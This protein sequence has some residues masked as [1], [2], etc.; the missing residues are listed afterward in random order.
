MT[1]SEKDS[2]YLWHP[3]TQ[4]KTAAVPIAISRGEGV[5]L[6]DENNKEYI[7]AIASWWVNPFGHSNRFIADAIYKQLTTLEH[8]LF[9]GFTHEPAI[10]LAERLIEILP[11]N[12]QKIFFSDN[13]STAVEVAIKVALQYF[14]NKGEKRTTIIA[15]ENAFHGDTFAAMAASG[16]SFYT[17]A[18]QGMFI[19]V[20]R[21]PVPVKG[22]EQVSFDVLKEVIRDKK[23]AGF[24]FEPLV[25]GAAGMVMY[26]P[27]ALATLIEI[28]K[29]NNVLTI[30]DEVMT[31]F[32]KT[33]KTFA[34][35]YLDENPDMMC[36]SKALTGGTIPMAITTFTQEV[37]EAFYD[38]DINKA[39][40]HGHTFTANPTGCAAALASI[41][42]LQTEEMQ[43]NIARV[44]KRH[45]N[46]QNK[47]KNHSK[48]VTTR[49]LG[50]IFALEIK[51][52]SEESYYGSMRTKLYNFFID[53]GVIL[54]PV[55][56]IVYILPPYIISDNQLE[57]VY[58]IIEEAIEMV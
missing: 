10:V 37:F 34:M 4:H 3:Y 19:D 48:V 38:D 57:K 11:K 36:L 50:V 46:F 44:N 22:Q 26:E 24:L 51:S 2:Q 33:G 17:Q 21:I 52:D 6:W 18:F 31:G 13:G 47:I 49:V 32:G 23:C 29:E 42:L 54:R 12:Q 14:F 35:D 41:D 27:E 20:V 25:Q 55:G 45:L 15:F 9:G 56:N 30:A 39:L 40:F 7:D 5:L 43:I 53:K 58:S 1:L 8:V 16:I 28:C